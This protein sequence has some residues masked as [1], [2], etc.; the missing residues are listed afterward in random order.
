MHENG[1]LPLKL[2][3]PLNDPSLHEIF[4]GKTMRSVNVLLLKL[5]K[6]PLQFLVY[7][8]MNSKMLPLLLLFTS[9]PICSR[10]SLQLML[11]VFSSCFMLTQIKPSLTLCAKVSERDSGHGQTP[12]NLATLKLGTTHT[13]PYQTPL[14]G[15]SSEI[16][17][18]KKSNL[19]STHTPLA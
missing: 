15:S 11:I 9:I 16:N 4:S 18:M 7:Q 10:L 5:L 1:K 13:D 19:V 12:L 8:K 3:L 6:L 17:M 14:T 2:H